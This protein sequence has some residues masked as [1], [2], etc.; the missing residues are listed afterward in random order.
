MSHIKVKITENYKDSQVETIVCRGK[1][2][3]IDSKFPL[4]G[5]SNLFK[6]PIIIS[7]TEEVEV[8]D[9]TLI[10][11][12]IYGIK[13]EDY[14]YKMGMTK[15][16]ALPEN[17]S[18]KHLQAIVDGKL[19]NGDEVLVECVA[20][21]PKQMIGVSLYAIKFDFNSHI[22]LFPV[23]KEETMENKLEQLANLLRKRGIR[24]YT[25]IND[26]GYSQIERDI[27]S[28]LWNPPTKK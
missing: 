23:K 1:L 28:L 9:E 19:K 21:P 24:K 26:M 17:F 25:C 13:E 27:V 4:I 15:I 10:D 20:Y 12:K 18:P 2:V 5:T 8:G 16:F 22:K 11:G 6:Q 3:L 7:E 14:H